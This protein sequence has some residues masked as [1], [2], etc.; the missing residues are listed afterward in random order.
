MKV[1]L[2]AIGDHEDKYLA[3]GFGLYSKRLQHY[4]SFDT[5]LIPSLKKKGQS[6]EAIMQAESKEILKKIAPSDLL[7]VLDEKGKEYSSVEFAGQMQKY[8]NM[9]GK[10]MFFLIGGAFGFAPEIYQRANQKISLSRLTFNHQMARLFFLEQLYRAM[11][12]LKGE[13]YHH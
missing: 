4:I 6:R 9:P 5:Q 1:T 8:L 2:I 10:K 3:E 7:I 11:T 12:I 13:P